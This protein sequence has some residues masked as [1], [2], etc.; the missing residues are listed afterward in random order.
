MTILQAKEEQEVKTISL[1]TLKLMADPV[2]ARLVGLF[3][4]GPTTVQQLAEHMKVPLTRLYYHVHLLE[5]HGLLQVVDQQPRGGTM[6]KVYA[7]TARTFL[8]DRAE[9]ASEPQKALEQANVLADFALGETT[10]A[11]RKSVRDGS[12]N[13]QQNPPHPQAL[14]IRRGVGRISKERAEKLHQRLISVMEEFTAPDDQTAEEGGEYLLA[15]A[16]FPIRFDE[17][18]Q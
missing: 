17:P 13:L 9:F 1:Q 7:T 4:G 11:L 6:E 2:R 3:S 14:Q 18:K 16:L 15:L 12:I 10:K 5:E 8:I